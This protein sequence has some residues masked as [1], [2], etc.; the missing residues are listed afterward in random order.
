M[1]SKLVCVNHI[2][3][4]EDEALEKQILIAQ[5]TND[6]PGLKRET[7]NFIAELRLPNCFT[8]KIPQNSL[9]IQVSQMKKK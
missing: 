3:H 6:I 4:I 2:L 5:S 7:D 8:C 1:M 9:K